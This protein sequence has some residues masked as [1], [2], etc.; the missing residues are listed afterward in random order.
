MKHG[1][2]KEIDWAYMGAML[3][4]EG[5]VEQVE[6]ISAFLKECKTWGTKYQVEKQ[7]AFVNAKLTDEEKEALSMLSFNEKNE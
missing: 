4:N 2:S 7:F 5:D 1:L 6:F 3:A